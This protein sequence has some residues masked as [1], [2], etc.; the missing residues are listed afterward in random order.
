[1]NFTS[2]SDAALYTA[3][4]FNCRSGGNLG[5]LVAKEINNSREGENIWG[6]NRF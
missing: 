6:I 3:P 2:S 5:L 4:Q 1:M